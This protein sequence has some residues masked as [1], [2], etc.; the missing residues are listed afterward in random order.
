MSSPNIMDILSFGSS[1]QYYTA[2]QANARAHASQP[3]ST[4]L[5]LLRNIALTRNKRNAKG[6]Q[7]SGKFRASDPVTYQPDI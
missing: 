1:P 7:F 2:D 5:G 4:I 6:S 3:V